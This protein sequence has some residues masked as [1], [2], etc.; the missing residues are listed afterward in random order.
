MSETRGWAW[1]NDPMYA[2]GACRVARRMDPQ[3]RMEERLLA[4]P[5]QREGYTQD[6]TEPHASNHQRILGR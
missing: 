5:S 2:A 6:Q 4:M 3:R 1:E